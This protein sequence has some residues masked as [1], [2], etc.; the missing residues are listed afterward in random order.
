M[1]GTF[2]IQ[3]MS[4]ETE[5]KI[6]IAAVR[7]CQGAG[8]P[9]EVFEARMGFIAGAISDEAKEHWQEGMY[10]RKQ[11]QEAIEAGINEGLRKAN[12]GMYTE[13]AMRNAFIAGRSFQRAEQYE[14]LT[15]EDHTI[16]DFK[17]WLEQ[18]KKK[19]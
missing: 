15:G 17:E 13:E 4:K 1:A 2:N 6:Q 10:D 19:L 18:N 3:V 7:H 16:P 12:E 9:S 5:G 14:D 11:L 8:E